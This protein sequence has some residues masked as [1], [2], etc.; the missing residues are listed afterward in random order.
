[1]EIAGGSETVVV[2][3][4]FFRPASIA[5]LTLFLGLAPVKGFA[6]ELGLTSSHVCGLWTNINSAFLELQKHKF[7]SPEFSDQLESMAPETFDGKRSASVYERANRLWLRLT[8]TFDLGHLPPPPSWIVDY[9]SLE[10]GGD[11][12][13]KAIIPSPVFVLSSQIL[14][15]LVDSIVETTNGTVP[16]SRFYAENEMTGKTPNDV[17]SLMDLLGRRLDLLVSHWKPGVSER[18]GGK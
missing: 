14:N 7:P 15:A 1:M 4:G 11:G 13:K 18:R 10:V 16:I 2:R 17:F 5:L 8:G 9:Q 12:E 6:L 3:G